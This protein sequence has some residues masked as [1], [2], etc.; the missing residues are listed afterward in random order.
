MIREAVSEALHETLPAV[1]WEHFAAEAEARIK[2]RQDAVVLLLVEHLDNELYLTS[3][4][5]DQI[6][7]SLADHWQNA[8]EGWLQLR[9]TPNVP[10][11]PADVVMPY[12]DPDQKQAWEKIPKLQLAF[13]PF[14][15]NIDPADL[16]WW[17]EAT[18]AIQGVRADVP[19]P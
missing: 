14:S 2:R 6:S 1:Q 7:R 8:W 10:S 12:L 18:P 9:H 19:A 13:N 17:D 5:R 15:G 16:A 4:Q 11:L 3:E